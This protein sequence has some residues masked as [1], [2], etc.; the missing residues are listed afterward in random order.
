MVL[1]GSLAIVASVAGLAASQ[2]T[3]TIDPNSVSTDTRKQWC[4]SQTSMC[5]LICLQLPGASG[6]P[7]E[8]KCDYKSLVYSCICS[9]N[10]SPNA[11][12]YSQTIPYFVCTE[13][14]S[15]CVTNCNGEQQC[16]SNCRTK[17]PCGAQDPKRVNTTT[18]ATTKTAQATTSLPPFTGVPNKN[19][20]ASGPSGDL[21]HIYGLA[22]V[23]AGFFAG[24]ATLL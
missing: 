15:Q 2:T 9:N 19:G 13:Q 5:P 14:N 20:V 24:F 23:M 16:Q 18:S 7:N 6:S 4:Q 8:N 1:L 17:N 22:V 21:N 12:E 3:S 11:T 10:Q